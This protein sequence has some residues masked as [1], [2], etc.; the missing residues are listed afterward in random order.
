MS[1]EKSKLETAE[2]RAIE[3]EANM[4][5]AAQIGKELLEKLT[6]SESAKN[7]LEQN[8]HSLRFDLTSVRANEKALYEEINGKIIFFQILWRSKVTNFRIHSLLNYF[9]RFE[10]A[11][12]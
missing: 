4:K 11:V 7:E 3:A 8:I 10:P 9:F 6:E 12:S 1:E 2:A 5:Q